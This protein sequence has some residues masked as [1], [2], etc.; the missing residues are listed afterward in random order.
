MKPLVRFMLPLAL[1]ASACGAPVV[2][3][4]GAVDDAAG[5][6]VRNDPQ[7]PRPDAVD[8]EEAAV[9]QDATP[10][11]DA[12]VDQDAASPPDAAAEDTV[13]PPMDVVAPPMDATTPPMDVVTP[14]ADAMP[15]DAA[16]ACP[17]P[18]TLERV[19]CGRCG[20][21][22][23]FCNAMSVWE[24]G[25][26]GSEGV[27]TP[28]SVVNEACGRCG[29]RPR[30]CLNTCQL[31]PSTAMCT[32]EGDCTPGETRRTTAGCPA[33]QSRVLRCSAACALTEIAEVCRA[34]IPLDVTVLIDV[35]GSNNSN[36]ARDMPMMMDALI[37]PLL[38]LSS[39]VQVGVAYFAEFPVSPYGIA[40][41]R[42]F[43][44]GIEPGRAEA[45]LQAAI[46]ARPNGSGAD[47]EDAVVEPLGVLAGLPVNPLIT[48][49]Q[50]CSAGRIAGG[51]WRPGA[52]RLVV[53]YSDSRS[54]N[55]P[56]P[57]STM[58]QSPYNPTLFMTAPLLWPDVRDAL[59]RA[60]TTVMMLNT[61]VSSTSGPA[62]QYNQ[63]LMDLMQPTTDNL[64]TGTGTMS[65][66]FAAVSMQVVARAR[67]LA[68]L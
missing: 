12:L 56:I 28:G 45:A 21:R 44:A 43:Y 22:E 2:V 49:P 31:E 32:G 3:P 17:R 9:T 27:C 10:G 6:D 66:P 29:T 47:A 35:T 57:G 41:D 64:A 23:R 34:S 7:A 11:P 55:G 15:A 8:G 67:G 60:N 46:T 61:A 51:C 50:R 38:A 13:T 25:A 4:D 33:G 14:P 16:E 54:H 1:W 20:T 19:A 36:L 59:R 18:G 40:S 37:R 39:D 62:A 58:L 26:C 24:Y 42:P 5:F 52:A 68:G 30:R 63:M 53:L 65:M 48:A